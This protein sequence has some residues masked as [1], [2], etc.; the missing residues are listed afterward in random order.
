MYLLVYV[1]NKTVV[2]E[3][4]NLQIKKCEY[5]NFKFKIIF[6]SFSLKFISF[7]F[8][9]FYVIAH[10]S[11]KEHLFLLH[12]ITKTLCTCLSGHH[13]AQIDNYYNN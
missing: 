3:K 13:T 7:L 1:R 9:M 4:F 2:L 11:K 8:Y 6:S 5:K 10:N 12:W